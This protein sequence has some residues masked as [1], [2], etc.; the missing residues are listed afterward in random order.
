MFYVSMKYMWPKLV[1]IIKR[2]AYTQLRML[3]CLIQVSAFN[4]GQI[5]KHFPF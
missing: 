5:Y 4:F 1:S 2:K 3:K